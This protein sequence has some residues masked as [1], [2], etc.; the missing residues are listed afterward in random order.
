M[1]ERRGLSSRAGPLIL[2]PPYELSSLWRLAQYFGYYFWAPAVATYSVERAKSW[3]KSR[4]TS[5]LPCIPGII[6]ASGDFQSWSFGKSMNALLNGGSRLRAAGLVHFLSGSSLTSYLLLHR[7][8]SAQVGH[9]QC[10]LVY[11]HHYLIKR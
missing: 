3:T 4:G 5:R 10:L 1:W 9:G 6:T 8:F 7:C 11:L 2:Y